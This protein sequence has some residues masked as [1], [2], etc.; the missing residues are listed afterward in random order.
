MTISNNDRAYWLD[1][2]ERIAGPVLK[3]LS[4]RQLKATMPVE[5]KTD[6]RLQYTHLE[7]LARTLTGLSSWL[8]SGPRDGEEGRLREL[9]IFR[10]GI[11]RLSIRL[12]W[13]MQC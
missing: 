1:T 5:V 9:S 11:S 3:A 12:F 6:T 13:R 2:L 4:M 10:R 7:A 8:E